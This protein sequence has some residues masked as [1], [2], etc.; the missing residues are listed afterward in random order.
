MHKT[1]QY[2]ESMKIWTSKFQV[3]EIRC[4]E[5]IMNMNHKEAYLSFYTFCNLQYN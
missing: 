2:D 3:L 5:I 4:S 1:H